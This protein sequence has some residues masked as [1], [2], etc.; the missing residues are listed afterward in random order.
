[1]PERTSATSSKPPVWLALVLIVTCV[2]V[3]F[4]N[5]NETDRF[6]GQVQSIQIGMTEAELIAIMGQPES[7][8][9]SERRWGSTAQHEGARRPEDRVVD[10]PMKFQGEQTTV[11]LRW[12]SG[13][14]SFVIVH[15]VYG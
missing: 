4:R 15:L 7:R 9:T 10:V 11:S 5:V 2:V 8:K 14:R 3:F 6:R 13:Y 1:M 12:N